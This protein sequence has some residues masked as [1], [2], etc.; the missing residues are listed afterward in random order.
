MSTVRVK[1][2]GITRGVDLQAAVAAGADALGFVFAQR[3]KRVLE[4]Q[5]ATDLVANAPAFVSRVGLFMDQGIDTISSILDQVPLNLLQFHGQESGGFCRRFGLPYIKAISMQSGLDVQRV[6]DEYGDAAALLLDSHQPGGVGGTGQ[7]FDWSAIPELPI[8]VILAGGL[9]AA[10][11][12]QAVEQ[13]KPWAVDV[14]SG[15]EDA[16]G[17]KNADRMREFIREAK[18]EY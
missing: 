14:S 13:V 18:R 9:T 8:P 4:P 7:V 5:Q 17:R 1:I 6:A 15:V 2:C 12:R 10:N 16:P 3:S 11:V